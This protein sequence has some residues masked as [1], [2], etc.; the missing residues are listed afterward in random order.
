[1]FVNSQEIS[2]NGAT[3][4]QIL[5]LKSCTKFAFR[6]S[7]ALD[8]AGGVN[9][10]PSC[11]DSVE[12]LMAILL[13]EGRRRVGGARRGEVMVKGRKGRGDQGRDFAHPKILAWRPAPIFLYICNRLA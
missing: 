6:W 4:C 5:R 7:S 10:A 1:M 3:R 8:P 2:K 12:Y 13:R 9:S 11:Q